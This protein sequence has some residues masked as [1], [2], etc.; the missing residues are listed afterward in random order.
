MPYQ[1]AKIYGYSLFHDFLEEFFQRI[2]MSAA[3]STDYSCYSLEDVVVDCRN[4]ENSSIAVG[5]N[6][7]ESW[8]DN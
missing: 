5:V 1:A 4:P 8:A 7:N 3:V 2:R 6:V